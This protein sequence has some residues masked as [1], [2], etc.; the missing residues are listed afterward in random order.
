MKILFGL[1]L[2]VGICF[3]YPVKPSW[4]LI[5]WAAICV[6]TFI[7]FAVDKISAIRGGWRVAEKTLHFYAAIGGSLA[8]LLGELTFG[9]KRSKTAFNRIFYPILILQFLIVAGVAYFLHNR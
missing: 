8:I 2:F 5:Y 1:L 9:H 7:L 6:V 3:L 4:V